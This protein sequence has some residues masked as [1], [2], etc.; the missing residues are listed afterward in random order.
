MIDPKSFWEPKITVW[1]EGRYD[2]APQ[3]RPLERLADA[4]SASLRFRLRSAVELLTPHV[5]GLRVADLGC[6]TARLAKPLLDAGASA[7][8]GVDLAESAIAGA[9]ARARLEGWSDRA[10][11]HRADIQ[12]LPRLDVDLVVS[13]GLVDWLT[14]DELRAMFAASGDAHFL[15]AI[16]EAQPSPAQ[17]VHR[18]YVRVA[19]GWWNGGYVPRYFRA[20]HLPKLAAPH[21]PGPYR[22]W[23]HPGLAFGAYITTLPIGEP[24]ATPA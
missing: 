1:E 4:A 6:G 5:R 23:R 21:R 12:A 22:V 13:L 2:R 7:Y 3:G 9:R 18:L 24:L 16:A 19:Y 10:T 15:H 17:L 8:V 20:N 14:D 11:L